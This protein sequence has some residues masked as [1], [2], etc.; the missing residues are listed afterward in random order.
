MPNHETTTGYTVAEVDAYSDAGLG[1]HGCSFL[2]VYDWIAPY[3]RCDRRETCRSAFSS[4]LVNCPT[5]SGS[6]DYGNNPAGMG[7][8]PASNGTGIGR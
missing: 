5:Y 2:R 1:R 3:L 8:Y 6:D 4:H 7:P